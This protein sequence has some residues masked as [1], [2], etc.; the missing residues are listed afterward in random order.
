MTPMETPQ[1]QSEPET[2]GLEASGLDACA[3]AVARRYQAGM[4][5]VSPHSG[6]TST[7][8]YLLKDLRTNC[9]G[10]SEIEYGIAL[11]QAFDQPAVT[12]SDR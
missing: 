1:H 11:N 6:W 2:A 3:L 7:W 8:R 10:F 12:A 9:P 4:L 5:P